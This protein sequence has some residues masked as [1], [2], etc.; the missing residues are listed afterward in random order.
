[1]TTALAFYLLA[2]LI[3]ADWQDGEREL[4]AVEWLVLT[5]VGPVAVLSGVVQEIA[6][7]AR[8]ALR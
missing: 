4:G 2:G 7:I 3:C 5:L 6:A 8:R 1:M